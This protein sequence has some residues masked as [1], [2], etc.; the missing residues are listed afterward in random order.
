[1]RNCADDGRWDYHFLCPSCGRL[2]AGESTAWLAVEAFAAGS[3][4]EVWHLPDELK[5]SHEGPVLSLV[6]LVELHLALSE[7]DWFDTLLRAIDDDADRG[8]AAG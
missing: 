7:P 4:L 6:D 1:L 5:E 8:S 3:A 2:T